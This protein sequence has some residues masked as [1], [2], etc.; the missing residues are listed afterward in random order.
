MKINV[1]RKCYNTYCYHNIF[2]IVE[3]SVSYISNKKMLRACLDF[4]FFHLSSVITQFP[5]L[6]TPHLKSNTRLAPSFIFHHSTFFTLFVGPMPVTELYPS[7]FVPVEG[8][9]PH[10]FLFSLFS[11]PLPPSALSLSQSTNSNP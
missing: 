3:I 7:C 1:L 8:F 9:H 5:S 10:L 11:F 6:I 4:I 2:T